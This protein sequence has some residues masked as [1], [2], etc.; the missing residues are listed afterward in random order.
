MKALIAASV[1]FVSLAA[2]AQ[3]STPDIP[4]GVNQSNPFLT[5]SRPALPAVSMQ[6]VRSEPQ[7]HIS[8]QPQPETNAQDLRFM[9]EAAQ[10]GLV[11]IEM[12][13]LAKLNGQSDAVREFG[14]RLVDDHRRANQQ[15]VLVAV[16]LGVK[17][18]VEPDAD[19]QQRLTEIAALRG[20]EFHEAFV[21]HLIAGHEVA[22]RVFT[23]AANYGETSA[24]REFAQKM[25][26]ILE[27]QLQIAISLKDDRKAFTSL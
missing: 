13:R 15:L 27:E 12:G 17:L 11:E 6:P 3:E 1:L 7:A 9:T 8:V 14:Q 10:S 5:M 4:P 22:L 16:Q 21:R 23:R 26:P 25:I 20:S 2:A 24:L 18:P 19:R